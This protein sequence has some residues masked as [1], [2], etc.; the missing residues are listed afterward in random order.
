MFSVSSGNLFFA[1]TALAA[2]CVFA[3]QIAFAQTTV[4]PAY[5]QQ[6][7]ATKP[8]AGAMK[9]TALATAD[10]NGDGIA[11]LAVAYSLASGRGAIAIYPG[12]ADWYKF[13][14]GQRPATISPFLEASQILDTPTAADRLLTGDFDGDGRPDLIATTIGTTQLQLFALD[15]AHRFAA[16]RTRELPGAIT[17]ITSG[18]IDRADGLADV[19]AGIDDAGRAGLIVLALAQGAFNAP[20]ER[21]DAAAAIDAVAIDHPDR[22]GLGNVAFA[23]GNTLTLL[24]GRDAFPSD[25]AV[26]RGT[27][28]A[29]A[30]RSLALN[31]AI[32]AIAS[33]RSSTTGI[34]QLHVLLKSGAVVV[35]ATSSASGS[36]PTSAHAAPMSPS[37]LDAPRIDAPQSATHADLR[38]VASSVGQGSTTA[39]PLLVSGRFADHVLILGSGARAFDSSANAL[40]LTANGLSANIIA[41]APL[42]LTRD[43]FDD[44]VLLNGGTAIN[45]ALSVSAQTFIVNSNADTDDGSCAVSPGT[46]TLRDAINAA[47]ATTGATISFS[48]LTAGQNSIAVGTGGLPFLSVPMTIDGTTAP[49][50]R[51]ELNG[52]GAGT[53]VNGLQVNGGTTVIRGMA[54]NLFN[55]SG[56]A[57][58]NTGGNIVENNYLG[59][60][61]TGMQAR[62]NQGNGIL[63]AGTATN[64][65]GGTTAAARNV[66]SGN[67]YPAL[68]IT[69][70]AGTGNIVQ[71]NY[72]GV[73][74]SGAVLL[75]NSTDDVQLV[76]G[77][78]NNSIGGTAA[79]AGNVISGN[80]NAGNP[81]IAITG[82]PAADPD[83]G[84][85]A[86]GNLL[87][88][89]LIG[90][91]A[92]GTASLGNLSVAVFIANNSPGN[93][94]GGN[95]AAAMNVIAGSGLDGIRIGSSSSVG[96][97]VA[98]N[99]I[100]TNAAGTANFGNAG[101]GIF[102]TVFATGTM[103]G[104]S[105]AA[106]NTI[107]FNAKGGVFI[108]S[109]NGNSVLE[110]S[111]FGN[112]SLGIDL[113]AN[114]DSTNQVCTD[115]ATVT[116][117]DTGD[118][119]TGANQLQNFPLIGAAV[120]TA[121]ALIVDATLNSAANSQFTIRWFGNSQCDGSGYGEGQRFLGQ[122]TVMTD[123]S[124]NMNFANTF[125]LAVSPGSF[126][127]ATATDAQ[128]NTSEFSKCM[129]V[130]PDDIFHN[131]FDP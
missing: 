42:R 80:G 29:R 10:W 102:L 122:Q 84:T 82:I 81:S 72:I 24:G 32:G 17:A 128:G 86:T 50:G 45:V 127:T 68:A 58:S 76:N 100:G 96:N 34:E 16:M 113:C 111:I 25:A 85:P 94:V 62:A 33:T 121:S 95:S 75:S 69:D 131:G 28:P 5:R 79:G 4:L 20:I 97:I 55:Y 36:A 114:F 70:A 54:I 3:T 15:A 64:T 13:A 120:K 77:A 67:F 21:H 91:N 6:T 115:A 73:D 39:A 108:D 26:D 22:D 99:R 88:G 83:P 49:D 109:G 117:N 56:I 38:I 18:E 125:G 30:V 40:S 124:G 11:D 129:A 1:R 44:L 107:A 93:T 89:N 52:T 12:N 105:G 71:G 101:R 90:T 2:A 78:S 118:A 112:T 130:V 43:A 51:V 110:N 65:I 74:V 37:A 92:A 119:D 87:Q 59:T 8:P 27:L 14:D 23:S 106:S 66:I 19:V 47:N 57:L 9:A 63:V 46:C 126:V 35:V 123:A 60:D 116:P 7:L 31:D 61:L 41:A 48:G 104:G 98:G 53:A 103:I